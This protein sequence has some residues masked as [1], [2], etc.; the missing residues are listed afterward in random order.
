[1][2]GSVLILSGLRVQVRRKLSSSG[3]VVPM[4]VSLGTAWI[5]RV[6]E[7]VA[8]GNV[9]VCVP[10]PT[11]SITP[12][13]F[14]ALS[15]RSVRQLASPSFLYLKVHVRLG[16][17]PEAVL[18]LTFTSRLANVLFTWKEKGQQVAPGR[19]NADPDTLVSSTSAGYA[20]RK[21]GGMVRVGS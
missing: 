8:S 9:R 12:S 2:T 4:T 14:P 16:V 5:R 1:M 13:A 17:L 18:F 7:V 19:L 3:E 15:V 11:K 10:S 20:L 6:L 21:D